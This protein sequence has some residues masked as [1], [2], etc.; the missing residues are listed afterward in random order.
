MKLGEFIKRFS[1]NNLIRLHYK[2]K[3]GHI[4]VL[5]SFDDVSMDWEIN[6]GIGKNRHYI[7]NEVI[8]LVGILMTKG[9]YSD[10]INI[11]IEKLDK[12]PF[13]DEMIEKNIIYSSE[14]NLN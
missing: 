5:D 14:Y 2:T 11:C 1:H 12:Q 6:K 10:A 13:I 8:G 3:E 9:H 7:N 4:C